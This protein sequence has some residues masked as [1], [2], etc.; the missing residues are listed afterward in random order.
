M[1]RSAP[2]VVLVQ[3]DQPHRNL[4]V[5]QQLARTTRVFSRN[6]CYRGK[7]VE[8]AQ[9]DIAQVTQRRRHDI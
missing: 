1:L 3:R 5:R 6:C 2:F 4:K 9:S 7:Y 8:C